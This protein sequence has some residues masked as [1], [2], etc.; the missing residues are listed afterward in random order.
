MMGGLQHLESIGI[1][2]VFRIYADGIVPVN[3]GPAFDAGN[4]R[5]P[6]G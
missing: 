1:G 4:D 5:L 6:A 2:I 3:F